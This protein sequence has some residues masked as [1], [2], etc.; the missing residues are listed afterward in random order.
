MVRRVTFGNGP[1]DGHSQV[2]GAQQDEPEIPAQ[3]VTPARQ[4]ARTVIQGTPGQE[5]PAQPSK[6]GGRP[7]WARRMPSRYSRLR[8]DQDV[9]HGG[10]PPY[11]LLRQG[12]QQRGGMME[13]DI[14]GPVNSET[15]RVGTTS[16]DIPGASASRKDHAMCIGS[17]ISG[18]KELLR[19]NRVNEAE[20]A[21]MV[22]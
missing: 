19:T 4:P 14:H 1:Q 3:L 12:G 7:A 16:S 2:D 5:V 6:G 13:D 8:D 9:C 20:T 18:L 22:G 17:I 11:A 10:S 21:S 15:S